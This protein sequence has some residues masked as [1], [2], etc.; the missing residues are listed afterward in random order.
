MTIDCDVHTGT[1]TWEELVPYLDAHWVGVLTE[2]EFKGPEDRWCFFGSD[3][4]TDLESV[5]REV[6]RDGVE[7]AVLVCP[8]AA[9]SIR[10]PYAAATM[11]AAVN[12]WQLAEWLEPEPRL[13]GSIVVPSGAP[14]LAAAEI[15]RVGGHASFVQVVVPA[16]SAVPY[17]SREF[18]P[19]FEAAAEL[20]LAVCIHAGGAPGNPPTSSGWPSYLVEELAGGAQVFQTQLMSLVAEGVLE[21]FPELKV[22]CAESGFAWVPPFLWRFDKDW[23]G[24]RREI[25]WVI[26][27]PSRVIGDQVRFTT[28]PLDCPLEALARVAARLPGDVLLRSS[29]YPE[30]AEP[31]SAE[32]DEAFR[33]A[34]AGLYR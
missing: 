34:A 28:S 13:R 6:L 20:G 29:A 5:R 12:D 4:R 33:R 21:R 15:R 25:P 26:R 19:L 31:L 18:L 8:Y 7:F 24:L 11:A 2:T 16:R 10:N 32:H 9:D 3:T 1:P 27:P 17:G 22:V 14:D 30:P 23:K